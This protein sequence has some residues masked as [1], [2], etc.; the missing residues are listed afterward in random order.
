VLRAATAAAHEVVAMKSIASPAALLETNLLTPQQQ[1]DDLARYAL[2]NCEFAGRIGV[3]RAAITPPEGIHAR[4]WGSAKH[5]IPRGVHKP[6]LA[7]CLFF[8]DQGGGNPLAL[9]ALDLSW[10]RS[11]TDERDLRLAVLDSAGLQ[12]H[13]LILHVSHTHAAPSTSLDLVSRPG[14]HL[15]APFR[16]QI[17]ETCIRLVT[18]A[19]A[20]ATPATLSWAVGS[21]RLA[22]NR[23]LVSPVDG[24][25]VVGLN[26]AR[27][28]DDTLLVGRI[29]DAAGD[30]RATLVNYACHP[31]SLGGANQLISPDYVGAMRETIEQ[32]TGGAPCAFL[33]GASGDL[34][35]RRSFE[36]DVDAA[37]Q[38]G[39]EIGHAA[40]ATL[41]SMLPAGM[42]L[43]YAGTEESGTKLAV[44]RRQP[45]ASNAT[46]AVRSGVVRLELVEMP[47]RAEL[48]HAINAATEEYVRERLR[49]KLSLR[50]TVGDGEA[51]DFPYVVWRLGDS[52]IVGLPAEAHSPFQIELRRQFP[53]NQIAVL[54][55]VNGYLS[56][57]PPR[58]DY[59]RGSYQTK[60]AIYTAGASEE[61]LAAVSRTIAE[62]LE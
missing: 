59:V 30:I 50:E 8:S 58:E 13:Q 17:K 28:A 41:V 56:Y 55:I 11:S 29:T 35:P 42:S 14:G 15:I 31:T 23:Q 46:I 49:R 24:E 44:W 33:H 60:V 10:W 51:A 61:V 27:S 43:A 7:T 32:S 3:A 62:L 2:R 26:P 4:L 45:V 54:N 9:V 36:A 25:V 22:F 5:D 1:H 53:E 12:Q 52:F 34:T 20:A 40:L 16:A 6:L 38:N 21:C 18:A 48:Q 57:L 47:T 39:R 37:D 19:R